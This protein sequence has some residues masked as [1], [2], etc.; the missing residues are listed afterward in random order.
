MGIDLGSKRI[1]L[2]ISD[3]AGRTAVPMEV[4]HRGRD[5]AEDHRRIAELVQEAEAEV[6]VVGLPL[7]L[8]GGDGPAARRARKEMKA[9]SRSVPV[10]VEPYDERLS[11]TEAEQ[12]LRAA[13]LDSRRMRSV[14]DA[15]A[16]SVILQG[17][18]DA[19]RGG[20]TPPETQSEPR[21]PS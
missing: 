1:G 10:P 2:A 8:D 19:R 15:A 14:I 12:S 17:W 4:I 9:L 7:S 13:E 16:A 5:W 20:T 6:V 3:S 11:T 21:E 18:L